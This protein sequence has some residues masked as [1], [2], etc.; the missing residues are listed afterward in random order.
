MNKDVD[1]R[2]LA[3]DRG[4]PDH[5]GVPAPSIRW[6][7]HLLTRYVLPLVIVV[8]NDACWNAE[9]QIQ[10]DEYGADRLV[11]CELADTHYDELCR[12]MGGWGERV[13]RIE[14]LSGALHRAIESGQPAVV[15][16]RID[17][18]KAPIVRR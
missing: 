9:Y 18:V 16:V 7:Q 8:G 2:E 17:R 14:D 11:A 6:R 12:S 13:E 3:I 10:L 4:G 1:L 15:D 5:P